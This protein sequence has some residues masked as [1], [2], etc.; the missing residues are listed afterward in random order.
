MP[1]TF[2]SGATLLANTGSPWVALTTA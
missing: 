2:P 1:A